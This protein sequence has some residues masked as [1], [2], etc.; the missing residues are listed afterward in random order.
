M[1]K[2]PVTKE[3]VITKP[4]EIENLLNGSN[5]ANG[6]SE[7]E[8]TVRED[9][10]HPRGGGLRI[11]KICSEQVEEDGRE[12]RKYKAYVV[13]DPSPGHRFFTVHAIS[14]LKVTET[15]AS[16][17]EQRDGLLSTTL[18]IRLKRIKEQNQQTTKQ[19]AND[20]KNRRNGAGARNGKNINHTERYKEETG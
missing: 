6:Y 2:G 10:K 20:L 5:P 4:D 13:G 12:Y 9:T 1:T 19:E 18:E 7:V 17:P 3:T 15:Y 14:S 8:L 16:K 11:D